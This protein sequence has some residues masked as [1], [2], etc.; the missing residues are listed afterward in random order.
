MIARI[1]PVLSQTDVVTLVMK[2]QA[3][4]GVSQY[5]FV[6]IQVHIKNQKSKGLGVTLFCC[7]T[8]TQL[9]KTK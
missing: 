7:A 2:S 1:S 9:T 3:Q 8:Q 6:T 4:A 5:Q